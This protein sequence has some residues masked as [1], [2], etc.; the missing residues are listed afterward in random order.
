MQESTIETFNDHNLD[1][2]RGEDSPTS[3]DATADDKPTS[4][5]PATDPEVTAQP[6]DFVDYAMVSRNVSDA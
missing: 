2:L 1:S 6:G 5:L 4:A 3:N